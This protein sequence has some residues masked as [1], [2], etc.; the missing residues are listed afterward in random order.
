MNS[1]KEM[2]KKKKFLHITRHLILFIIYV[3]E[4]KPTYFYKMPCVLKVLFISVPISRKI[5]LLFMRTLLG[6]L[7]VKDGHRDFHLWQSASS[8]LSVL[9]SPHSRVIGIPLVFL[10]FLFPISL[11]SFIFMHAFCQYSTKSLTVRPKEHSRCNLCMIFQPNTLDMIFSLSLPIHHCHFLPHI[12]VPG[13]HISLTNTSVYTRHK[14]Q[15]ITGFS[16]HNG[17]CICSSLKIIILFYPTKAGG[18][19]G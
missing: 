19:L 16:S 11:L 17:D 13:T 15:V 1:E 7:V 14:T 4:K 12:L 2:G 18:R 3:Q 10:W 9:Y 5:L 6:S 8:T